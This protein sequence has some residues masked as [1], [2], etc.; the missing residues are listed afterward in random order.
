MSAALAVNEA[1]GETPALF[2]LDWGTSALR[3]YALG[4][5]GRVLTSRRSEHG[6]MNLPVPSADADLA[7]RFELA[8]QQL[9]GDWLLA[10]ADVPL[11]ACGMVGS[12]QGWKEAAYLPLPAHCA[13]LGRALTV[14]ARAQPVHIVPGLIQAGTLPN[15]MRG[16][17]TQIAGVLQCLADEGVVPERLLIGLPGTHSK[18]ALVLSGAITRFETFMTGEVFA[19]LR[20][21]S[22]LGRSMAMSPAY[23]ARAFERGLGVAGSPDG[24][25]GLLSNAFS[26]RTLGLTGQLSGDAQVDY[27]SG[28]LIGHEV[29][30]LS[31]S[32]LTKDLPVL[33]CGDAQLCQR[34]ALALTQHGSEPPRI[35]ADATALG[36]WRLARAGKLV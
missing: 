1:L 33:L 11:L 8:L 4:A 23:D 3:A 32:L 26:C 10:H 27:L 19:V 16:E 22:I 28:L 34:Y 31:R 9:C 6:I 18:W 21:H 14:V 24:A 15:V 20:Q 25:M 35:C 29:G 30:A 5:G 13:D 36:L 7:Q 17:E 12:A 2:G